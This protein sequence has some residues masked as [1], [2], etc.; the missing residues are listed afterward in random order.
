MLNLD[1]TFGLDGISILFFCLSNFL[2]FLCI[3]F[4]LNAELL[5]EFLISLTF[6]N[7]LLLLIFSA[8]DLFI[9]YV[10][11]EA[12]LIPMSLLIGLWGSR[13]RKIRAFYLFF[14]YTLVGSLLM[15]LGILYIHIKTGTS[16]F[17]YL[18]TWNFTLEEQCWLW[19][20][21]LIS[22]IQSSYNKKHCTWDKTMTYTL[23]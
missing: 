2:V 15:L 21:F 22:F 9:F 16:S 19:L 12:V 3:I 14:F 4:I 10:F 8:L 20:S 6:I 23:Q 18:L 13:E 17:E 7:L 11:F 5:K 1:F